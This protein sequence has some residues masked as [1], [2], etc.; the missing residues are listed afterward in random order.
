[1][2]VY[3][4]GFGL[5]YFFIIPGCS[6]APPLTS[7]QMLRIHSVTGNILKD[8]CLSVTGEKYA[9]GRQVFRKSG[10]YRENPL[11]QPLSFDKGMLGS[12]AYSQRLRLWNLFSAWIMQ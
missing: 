10:M 1:M 6:I 2:F 7:I 11:S 3:F 12:Q 8:S 4:C 5:W 9:S